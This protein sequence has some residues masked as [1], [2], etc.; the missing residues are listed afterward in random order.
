MYH[1]KP[2]GVKKTWLSQWFKV[3]SA[4]NRSL[5]QNPN[6]RARRDVTSPETSNLVLTVGTWTQKFLAALV[7]EIFGS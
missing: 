7:L 2:Q 1:S 3:H 4:P 5:I 6:F